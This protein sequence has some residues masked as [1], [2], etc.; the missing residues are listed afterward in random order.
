M[1]DVDAIGPTVST[2]WAELGE[3]TVLIQC[4][5]L[6][7]SKPGLKIIQADWNRIQNVNAFMM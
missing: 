5:G 7:G 3:V 1:S 2:I 4:A 6:M